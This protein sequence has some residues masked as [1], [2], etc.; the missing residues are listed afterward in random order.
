MDRSVAQ[1]RPQTAVADLEEHDTAR[2]PAMAIGVSLAVVALGVYLVTRADRFYD[3]FVWQAAAF[4]EGQAAIRYPVADS[5]DR[6]GNWFF[7]DVLPVAPIDGIARGLIPFPPLPAIVLLP[8]VAVLGLATDDQTL[9]TLL[10][11]AD[12]ALCWWMLGGL[13]LRPT[14][15]LW[16]TAFFAFGTAFWYSAQVATTWYQAHIV[17]VG[18]LL[19]A[20]GLT[21]RADPAAMAGGPAGEADSVTPGGRWPERLRVDRRAFGIGILFGLAATARL[22]VVF[23]A[24]FF[25]LVGPGGTWRRSWSTALGAAIP[26]AALLAYNIL[27]SGHV[28]HPAY[29]HLYQLEAR[30]YTGLG[31]DPTWAAEDPRYLPRNL[32][33]MLL[34]GPYLLPDRMRDSLGFLDRP[35]CTDP[36]ATRSLFDVRCPLA[37]P[38]DIGMSILLTSPALLLAWPALRRLGRRRLVT[39]AA[40]AVLSVAVVNLMHFSQG[41]VQFGYRFSNDFMPFAL[42]LVALGFERLVASERGWA[43][44][45]AVGLIAVS[46][47]VNAWG[48]IWSR[49]LGW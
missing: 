4:L 45:V 25:L 27:T 33:I 22:T 9:F 46:V 28:F 31:Y 47:A 7:Q 2:R 24:P 43:M 18:L 37:L 8:F 20:V 29:D 44:P 21:V 16:S 32:G 15:R 11:A 30:A 17:A 39:G 38:R 12:V 10:A 49:I 35:L 42:V 5:A 41:W 14:V 40:L 19:V 23:A 26:L 13:R 6:L 3:H 1:G 34:T 48:V 36:G